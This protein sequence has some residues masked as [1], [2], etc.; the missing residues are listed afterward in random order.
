VT[1][2]A[3]AIATP[4]GLADHVAVAV[5]VHDPVADYVN[6]N[7]VRGG[8]RLVKL[9]EAPGVEGRGDGS[10]FGGYVKFAWRSG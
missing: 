6:V 3:R 4:H 8:S 10:G 5:N 9:V 2:S 7:V 1:G